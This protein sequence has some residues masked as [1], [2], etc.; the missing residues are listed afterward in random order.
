M[1]L[2]FFAPAPDTIDINLNENIKII[3]TG[4]DVTLYKDGQKIEKNDFV[5]NITC[6]GE[7]W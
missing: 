1:N 2:Q 3:V 5:K 7:M 6:S 4:E